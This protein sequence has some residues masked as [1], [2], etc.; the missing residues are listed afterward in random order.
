MPPSSVVIEGGPPQESS[1]LS[2]P[3]L[4][5]LFLRGLIA[6]IALNP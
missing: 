4:F 6:T 5:I 3:F 2:P 1:P